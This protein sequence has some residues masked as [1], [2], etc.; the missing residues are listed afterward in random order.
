MNALYLFYQKGSPFK[1]LKLLQI[2]NSIQ[3]KRIQKRQAK[4]RQLKIFDGAQ[5]V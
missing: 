2:I 5:R 1:Q 3:G 4:G